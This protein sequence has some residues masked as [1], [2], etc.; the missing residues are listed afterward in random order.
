MVA[1]KEAYRFYLLCIGLCCPP[2]KTLPSVWPC[3]SET[4]WVSFGY[5]GTRFA[6]DQLGRDADTHDTKR[7]PQVDARQAVVSL[8]L[9]SAAEVPAVRQRT[10]SL[11]RERE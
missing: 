6:G 10:T 3:Y 4:A 2:P 7:G 11:H 1:E 8:M 5:M 9:A